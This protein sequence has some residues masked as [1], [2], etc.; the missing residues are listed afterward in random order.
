MTLFD[1]IAHVCGVTW[2]MTLIANRSRASRGSV[3]FLLTLAAIDVR[4][5]QEVLIV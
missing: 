2:S 1:N 4:A 3:S 5:V